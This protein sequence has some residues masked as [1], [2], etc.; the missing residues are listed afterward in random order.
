M[1]LDMYL[2]AEK[3]LSGYDKNS[4]VPATLVAA[5]M[6]SYPI[7]ENGH[8]YIS[9]EIGYWRKANHIHDWFVRCVQDGKDDCEMYSVDRE[10][11]VVLLSACR[12]VVEDPKLGPELLP[13]KSGF[14][15]GGTKYD[16]YYMS[17]IKDTIEILEKALAI[18]ECECDFK[19]RSSW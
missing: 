14:F 6:G 2:Y 9:V 10:H 8:A 7:A 5:G 17:D 3:Y 16:E 4:V 13:T 12:S 15:F 19:Y 11:L 1:G 18:P